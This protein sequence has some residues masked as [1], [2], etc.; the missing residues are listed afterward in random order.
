M[1]ETLLEFFKAM[2]HESRLRM[3]GLLAQR[4]HSVQELAEKLDLKE[5]TVSHH[6][7]ILKAQGLVT[8]RAEGTTRWHALD[9]TA[10]ERMSAQVLQAPAEKLARTQPKR[11]E[12][13]DTKVLR[14]FVRGDGTLTHMPAQRKKRGAVLRWLMR[15]FEE[16]RTYSEGEVNEAIQRHHW[17]SATLRRELIGHAMMARENRVYRRQPREMWKEGGE[18]QSPRT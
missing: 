9:R 11:P 17:D 13:Y 6:L 15:D 14:G 3:I 4:E 5:P 7:A 8:A 16:G 1:T 2:A 12:D 10:L 18:A